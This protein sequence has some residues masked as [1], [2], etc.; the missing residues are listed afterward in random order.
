MNDVFGYIFKSLNENEVVTKS[1]CKVV[2]SHGRAIRNSSLCICGLAMLMVVKTLD[3]MA[4]DREIA[5]LKKEI[6]ELKEK[7]E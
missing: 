7:G 6:K 3:D 5:K 2:N 4:R 1:M